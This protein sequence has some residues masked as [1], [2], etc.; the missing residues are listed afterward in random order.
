MK[1]SQIKTPAL[2][3]MIGSII[4]YP[5][6][7]QTTQDTKPPPNLH[8]SPAGG[9]NAKETR[10]FSQAGHAAL[11][12]IGDA[13]LAIFSGDPKVAMNLMESAK[14]FLTQADKDA[15]A[16]ESK[17]KTKTALLNVPVD[18]QLALADDYV[19]TPEKQSHIDKANDNFKKGNHASGLEELKLAAIDV[20]YTAGGCRWPRPKLIW[21]KPSS[22]PTKTNITKPTWR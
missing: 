17:N 1:Y 18:G 16:M 5:A 13:R 11:M 7:A 12:N 21:I 22:W 3:L 15:V 20:N 9:Q 2:V 8:A 19:M 10:Q 14:R 6:L 4:A